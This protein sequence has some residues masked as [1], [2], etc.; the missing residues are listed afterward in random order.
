MDAAGH[1]TTRP[2]SMVEPGLHKKRPASWVDYYQRKG[3]SLGEKV[4]SCMSSVG[5]SEVGLAAI[6]VHTQI[7][8]VW[9]CIVFVSGFTMGKVC[10][11]LWS[12][13]S[14]QT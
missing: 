13:W 2:S 4:S 6:R 14:M 8:A 12:P 9:N 3:F 5:L 1:S 7:C 10:D 11:Q